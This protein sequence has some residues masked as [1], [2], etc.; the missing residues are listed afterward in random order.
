MKLRTLLPSIIF[1]AGAITARAQVTE[2]YYQ[3]FEVGEN[4]NYSATLPTAIGYSTSLHMSGERALSL[5]Q[6][7]DE[8][9][10][11]FLDTLDF[12]QDNS[13]RF[14]S[15]EFDHICAIRENTGGDM[16]IGRIYCKRAANRFGRFG[17][18]ACS[19]YGRCT[20]RRRCFP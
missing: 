2:M 7:T 16:Y 1:L 15:L 19:R 20:C 8:D 3:G 17:R 13:L 5:T 12:R 9:I 18:H 10:T 6:S 11:F 4:I 14:I